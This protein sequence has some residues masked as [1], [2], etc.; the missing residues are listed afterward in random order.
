MDE[1]ISQPKTPNVDLVVSN[2]SQKDFGKFRRRRKKGFESLENEEGSDHEHER[3]EQEFPCEEGYH[4]LTTKLTSR[5]QFLTS[6][7]D[8]A[9]GKQAFRR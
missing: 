5:V 4:S 1:R 2:Y 6:A 7:S 3:K 8:L 9:R